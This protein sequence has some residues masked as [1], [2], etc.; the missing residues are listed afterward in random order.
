[1]QPQGAPRR[2]CYELAGTLQVPLGYSTLLIGSRD[3]MKSSK[4]SVAVAAVTTAL[5]LTFI[6]GAAW[7]AS[8]PAPAAAAAPAPAA[9]PA[10]AGAPAAPKAKAPKR[11]ATSAEPPVATINGIP[12][13][14]AVFDYYV[15]STTGKSV[16][17]LPPETRDQLLD[18]LIRGEVLSQQAVKEG[19]DKSQD[20]ASQV[21]L[22][23]LQ[24][25]GEAAA[26]SYLKDKPAT[27]T[28]VRAEYDAQIAQMPKTQYHARHILVSSQDAAQ[29]VIDQLKA[30]ASFEELAKTKS[31]DS[32]KDQGG[33]L[34]W[35]APSTMVKPFAT[36]VMGLKK[37]ETT[38]TPVQTPFGWHVI[39][40]LD[41]REETPPQF[42]TVKQRVQQLVQQKKV[43]DYQEELMKTAV[44][45]KNL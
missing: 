12:L 40:L 7:T 26:T 35:F 31:I 6:S 19:L 24:V 45:K 44:V 43:H 16:T 27:D 5:T 36:A 34:G 17:D 37:G 33:D 20:V 13:S 2:Q 4:L 11:A 10:A 1:M 21:V 23:H 3:L 32:T 39:E 42:E 38:Q 9:A 8:S 25:L 30:G 15:K 22:A 14:R 29:Q 41:T 18:S 28:Q